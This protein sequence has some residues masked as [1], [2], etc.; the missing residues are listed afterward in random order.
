MESFRSVLD[1]DNEMQFVIRQPSGDRKVQAMAEWLASRLQGYNRPVR[2]LFHDTTAIDSEDGEA[3]VLTLV[4]RTREALAGM[5][6]PPLERSLGESY[7]FRDVD[8][9][10]DFREIFPLTEYLLAKS[11]AWTDWLRFIWHKM[12]YSYSQDNGCLVDRRGKKHSQ[13]RDQS[14]VQFHYDLPSE[15]FQLWLDRRMVYSCAYFTSSDDELDEAQANKLDY[16]CRKLRLESGERV[17]DIGC[18]WGGFTIYAAQN[19]G[20]SVIGITLSL[21]QAEIAR[22][23]IAAAGLHRQCTIIVAD[24]R[25]LEG[26]EQFDKIVSIGMV[27][28]VGSS[29]LHL[30]F[31][32]AHRLLKPGG[33]FLNHGIASGEGDGRLGAFADRYVFPDAEVV[34]LQQIITAAEEGKWE[35]RDI[36]SLREHYVLTLNHWARRLENEHRRVVDLVGER[37]YRIWRLYLAASAE[38]FRKGRLG[39]YQTLLSK[40]YDGESDLPLTRD[41]WYVA[42]APQST[43]PNRESAAT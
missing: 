6:R 11:W 28:H 43:R 29:R 24:Y 25:D 20:V 23:R 19:Y 39:V 16:L 35:V 21:R 3:P 2:I 31:R 9:V 18:G 8:V 7:I 22:K 10:D 27:E 33:V 12:T 36:E 1:M 38:W 30:Y 42:S 34:P 4:L 41:D 13:M 17:L 37:T 5:F 14:V 15:F 40:T 32:Q 26:Q